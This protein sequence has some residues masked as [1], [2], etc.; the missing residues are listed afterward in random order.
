MGKTAYLNYERR[1]LK[2]CGIAG[3]L[4]SS[5]SQN[6]NL[7]ELAK[8][9]VQP[10]SHRGPDDT[11]LWSDSDSG[12]AL[13]H[14]RLA[15]LDLTKAG[16]Q[17]MISF[18]G[19]YIIVFN[20]EIYNHLE[21]RKNLHQENKSAAQNWR[22]HSDTETFL[23]AIS[24][25]GL[26]KTLNNV[27]G[28]CAFALWDNRNKCLFLARD[29]I[30]EKPLYYGLNQGVLLFGSELKALRKYPDFQ[31]E[32]D[33]DALSL[34]F[35]HNYI[36]CPYSIYQGIYKLPPATWVKITKLDVYNNRLPEPCS[37]WSLNKVASYGQA[38]LFKGSEEDAVVELERLLKNSISG[39]MIADV[40]IG[41][42][43]SGGVDSSTV[44]ALMQAQSQRS[45][46]TFTI[47]FYESDY[48]ESKH[49]KSVAEYIGTEH[50]EL[51]LSPENA[52]EVIPKL[53]SIY[54]EPFADASQ[55]PSILVSELA[56][57]DVKV[58]LSGDGG[59]ELFGGYNRH[60][61]GP[62]LWRRLGWLPNGVRLAISRLLTAV[63]PAKWDSQFN[64]LSTALPFEWQYNSAGDKIHKIASLLTAKSYNQIYEKLISQWQLSED[65]VLG[66]LSQ[67][68]FSQATSCPDDIGPLEHQMMFMDTT[69]YLPDD[70]LV[71]ID[72]ASMGAS[73]ETRV[74]M[75]DHRVVEFAWTLPLKMKI[76]NNQGKWLLRK[77]LY[78]HVPRS[79]IERPK[80]GFSVPL[81]VWLRGPL[82][83]WAE[84]L[85]DEKKILNQGYLDPEP[86]KHKWHEHLQGKRNWSH[87]LWSVLMF[88][89]WLNEIHTR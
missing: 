72:R 88:Q 74:P 10:L 46:K 31:A 39:Q 87:Q 65:P 76:K 57:K 28:M 8:D 20:G 62:A 73:L 11:G 23:A 56:Q 50:T 32:I 37:Y 36:P 14:R 9:M 40:P 51:F 84:E 78:N 16:H 5:S 81:D 58:S 12:I 38:N 49:T 54:D 80:S 13:A 52:L 82:K 69:N 7:N 2:M 61:Y 17:P 21:I 60:T 45:V 1:S 4:A 25:W 43:L 64:R 59:D 27:V 30:G 71:K 83:G 41:A 53:A 63:P 3:L 77:L 42:F 44:V 24:V 33:R 89:G 70:I 26:E 55:I 86:I 18:C 48:D 67:I 19:R 34:Y 75:L 15:I 68:S 85:L 6:K 47:G 29:R 66:S 22:G 35:Q 79:L